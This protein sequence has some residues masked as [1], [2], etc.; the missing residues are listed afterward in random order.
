MF[1]FDLTDEE[2]LIRD[3]A[4][5]FA[6][7]QLF[8]H[9]REYESQGAV[10]E[11][12]VKT[13]TETGFPK[14]EVPERM[15]GSE[16]SSLAK[17]LVLEAL[18]RGD[19]AATIALDGVGPAL[20]PLMEYGGSD[21]EALA[22]KLLATLGARGW[23]VIDNEEN[24]FETAEGRVRGSWPWVPA[25]S[26]DVLVILKDGAAWVITEGMQLEHLKPAA[27]QA[28]GSSSLTLDAPVAL[29]LGADA[30]AWARTLARLRV[31]A[32]ALL[33]GTAGASLDYAIAYTQERVAFGRPIAHHQGL[34]FL[35]A[36][37]AHRIDGARLA[38]WRACWALEQEGDPTEAAA[39]AYL[40]AIDVGLEMGEQGVQL[41][42]GHG[43]VTDHPVEKWMRE[44]RTLSLLWGG[45]AAA[46]DDATAGLFRSSAQVG[47]SLPRWEGA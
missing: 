47:F 37:L 34:A 19:A 14:I 6:G 36:E 13:F 18:A 15:G 9:F 30:K 27:L 41:L 4:G 24:R 45:R 32:S 23:V 44:G 3:T 12:L 33:V 1:E 7:E 35:I 25:E 10:P 16:L 40:D 39:S 31:Y 38:L 46:L 22:E 21:A 43:Y 28:A 11:P 8:A 29:T 17:A 20:Y 2:E 26:L 5:D 42:G